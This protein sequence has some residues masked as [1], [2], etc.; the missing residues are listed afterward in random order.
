MERE[1]FFG[2]RSVCDMY[3]FFS[4]HCLLD[5]CLNAPKANRFRAGVLLVIYAMVSDG[6]LHG[7]PYR[8][9]SH[10]TPPITP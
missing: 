2:I 3:F 7:K 5:V 4:Q 9:P 6:L 10:Y 8:R 1:A